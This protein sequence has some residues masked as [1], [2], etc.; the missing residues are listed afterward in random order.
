MS[1]REL[2]HRLSELGHRLAIQ[3]M[4][5]PGIQSDRV[6][7]FA[8]CFFSISGNF[9]ES[10]PKDFQKYFNFSFGLPFGYPIRISISFPIE[11]A[12]G[13]LSE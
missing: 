5:C 3:S 11:I 8:D 6:G 12:I 9:I 10:F 2:S 7:H 4:L 1:E 13:F